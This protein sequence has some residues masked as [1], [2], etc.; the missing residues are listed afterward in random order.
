MSRLKFLEIRDKGT[1]V[2]MLAVALDG[3]NGIMRRAGF[4]ERMILLS[5]LTDPRRATNWDVYG[6]APGRT[7]PIA[8]QWLEAHWDEV[9]DGDVIDVEFILGETT[10]KK[11]AECR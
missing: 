3:S 10:Q 4:G 7:F 11:D 8:H 5:N 6:W 9:A 1:T 2:P